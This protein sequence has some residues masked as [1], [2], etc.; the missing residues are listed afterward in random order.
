[1]TTY[2]WILARRQGGR[3]RLYLGL[4]HKMRT[5]REG[6]PTES[7]AMRERLAG[8]PFSS[9]IRHGFV[10]PCER[11]LLVYSLITVASM[12][13]IVISRLCKDIS[14]RCPLQSR[15]PARQR[16]LMRARD[17]DDDDRRMSAS[18][19]PRTG[20]LGSANNMARNW[21][22]DAV[23]DTSTAVKHAGKNLQHLSA[24]LTPK[25]AV[26]TNT[27]PWS[28]TNDLGWHVCLSY[29]DG[30]ILLLILTG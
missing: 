19:P 13:A 11:D 7:R 12:P 15:G 2:A 28:R 9:R 23:S 4:Q 6:A 21:I 25:R 29:N 1:M 18:E 22:K 8:A 30:P 10:E 5:H 16:I 20:L 17:V 26:R 24:A 27:C 3:R 14:S